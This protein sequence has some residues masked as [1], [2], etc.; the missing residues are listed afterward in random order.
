MAH[1]DTLAQADFFSRL[2]PEQLEKIATVSSVHEYPVASQIYSL[3]A[4]AQYF[5]VLVE[6]MV[7]F[8]LT[9]GSRQASA[10]EILRRGAVFGW[11][12]LI[13]NAQRRIATASCMTRCVVL[14]IDGNRL[15]ALMEQDHS[16]GYCIMKQLNIL[17]TGKMAAFAAG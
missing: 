14:A 12:A 13:E 10:G 3:D 1:L 6:G 17:I 9:L 16:L 8:N 7:R 11:A 4:S 15:L 5:Y 2:T